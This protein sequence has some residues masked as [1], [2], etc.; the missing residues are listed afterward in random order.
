MAVTNS[1]IV[2]SKRGVEKRQKIRIKMG[3]PQSL[4]NHWCPFHSLSRC[5]KV[6]SRYMK[7]MKVSAGTG[8]L[9]QY[10]EVNINCGEAHWNIIGPLIV[11]VLPS[12]WCGV[13]PSP[14]NSIRLCRHVTRG[15]VADSKLPAMPMPML[16]FPRNSV[17]LHFSRDLTNEIRVSYGLMLIVC[18]STCTLQLPPTTSFE[19]L[20]TSNVIMASW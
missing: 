16:P 13:F 1:L 3:N 17:T 19:C 8:G 11:R 12:D 4:L 5:I 20:H 2:P 6:T 14:D 10:V 15:T 9:S 18:W 7:D